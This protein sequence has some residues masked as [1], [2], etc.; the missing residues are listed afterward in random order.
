MLL[1]STSFDQTVPDSDGRTPLELAVVA[2]AP[3]VVEA[4]LDASKADDAAAPAVVTAVDERVYQCA[5]DVNA[6]FFSADDAS[7]RGDPLK[8][9]K[10]AGLVASDQIVKL[11]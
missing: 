1:T 3:Q 5:L 7:T 9:K 2:N 6:A 8:F 4:L 11:L 10:S